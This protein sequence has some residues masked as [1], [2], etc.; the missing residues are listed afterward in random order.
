MARELAVALR[1]GSAPCKAV[2]DAAQ[3]PKFG[4]GYKK[5]ADDALD[6]LRELGVEP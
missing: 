3:E 5:C 1:D 2:C 6:W 4:E